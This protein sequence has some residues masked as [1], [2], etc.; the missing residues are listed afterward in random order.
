M[1]ST[2][3]SIAPEMPLNE[4]NVLF[5]PTIYRAQQQEDLDMADV[6]STSTVGGVLSANGNYKTALD[7]SMFLA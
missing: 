4:A 3:A 1:D 7:P 2:Q 5:E 6:Q